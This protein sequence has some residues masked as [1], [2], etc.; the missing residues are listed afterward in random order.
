MPER[1]SSRFMGAPRLAPDCFVAPGAQV[2][3]D[4]TLCRQASVW[5]NA[6]LRGDIASIT[7]GP[8]SN[9]QDNC[10]LHCDCDI[11][12]VIGENVSVG[13]NAVLHSCTVEDGA[14]VG[15]GAIVLKGAKI[16]QGSLVGAGAVVTPGTEIPAG[17][18]AVGCPA[19]VV[20]PLTKAEKQ[21]L[22]Q[23]AESY[24]S[25]SNRYRVIEK[26]Q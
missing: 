21:E 19:R 14:L 13:H 5:H 11:P 7:V 1:E 8:R 3:G 24:V 25:L 23:N 10:T 18:L 15:M 22:L 4:V 26:E 17:H 16:G 2:L 12:L 20:R 6:V 9:V